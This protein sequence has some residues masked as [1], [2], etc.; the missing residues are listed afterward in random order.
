MYDKS[1]VKAIFTQVDEAIKKIIS[2]TVLIDIGTVA[3]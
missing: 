3:K 2:R 1:L